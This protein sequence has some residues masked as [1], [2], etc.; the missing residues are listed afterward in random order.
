ML[1]TYT[2][3]NVGTLYKRTA[4]NQALLLTG[5]MVGQ[6]QSLGS[7]SL[8]LFI[9][10]GNIVCVK[11]HIGSQDGVNHGFAK[12]HVFWTMCIDKFMFGDDLK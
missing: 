1:I 12:F 10:L 11:S 7:Q 5:S 4:D 9:N 6:I 2:I 3:A 8:E